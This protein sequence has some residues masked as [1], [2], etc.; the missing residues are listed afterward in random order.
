MLV[1]KGNGGWVG[2]LGGGE[3]MTLSCFCM[4][5]LYSLVYILMSVI[6]SGSDVILS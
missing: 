1:R 2:G 5:C 3:R 6:V 4:V